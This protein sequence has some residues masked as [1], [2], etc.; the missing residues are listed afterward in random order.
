L[1][2]IPE[3]LMKGK[4]RPSGQRTT[5]S[6]WNY[7]DEESSLLESGLLGSVYLQFEKK[8]EFKP[9]KLNDSGK[10]SLVKK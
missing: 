5:F 6:T 8:S 7:F 4:E 9:L 3:W 1:V 10:M 2:N